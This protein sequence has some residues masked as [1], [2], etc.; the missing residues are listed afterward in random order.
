MQHQTGPTKFSDYATNS[1]LGL[2]QFFDSVGGKTLAGPP[3]TG[4]HLLD[5]VPYSIAHPR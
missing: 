5:Q 4:I 2:S 3:R 1:Y